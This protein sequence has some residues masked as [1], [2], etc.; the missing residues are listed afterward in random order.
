[1]KNVDLRKD[2]VT[3][4]VL[5]LV[6]FVLGTLLF[7][8]SATD[9]QLFKS[10]N[11]AFPV[12]VVW[13]TLS[14]I[15][16]GL[17]I[18]CL[19]YICFRAYVTVLARCLIAGLL[20]HV[21]VRVAKTMIQHARP[22]HT[23]LFSTSSHFLGLPIAIGNYSMP[24]GHAC[25]AMMALGFLVL[26]RH[27]LFPREYRATL[28]VGTFSIALVV[29]FARVAVGAHWPSDVFIGSSLG[30]LIA[31]ASQM[32]TFQFLNSPLVVRIL[33]VPFGAF[34]LF[35]ITRI[36]S[37]ST[38]ISD[39]AITLIGFITLVFITKDVLTDR[40]NRKITTVQRV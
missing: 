29:V 34:S 28:I 32:L 26:N 2:V 4:L 7:S 19:L 8:N 20:V 36:D 27:L 37:Y 9:H 10:I 6:L 13:N 30:L 12:G 25:T 14:N 22:E 31:C 39:G 35:Q 3:L 15:G 38:L 24:S 40:R 16:D 11:S 5:A 33:Y 21:A 18:G 23:E 17:F 1:M